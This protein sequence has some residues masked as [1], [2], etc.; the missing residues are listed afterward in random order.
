MWT[1]VAALFFL[2]AADHIAEGSKALDDGK[3]E[4]AAQS[5]SKAIAADPKDVAAHFHLA[6]A[7]S[8]LNRDAEGIAEYRKALQLE[9]GLFEAELN[10]GILYL[11]QKDPAEA[12]PLLEHAA[13][14]KPREFRPR[15]YAAEAQLQSG[16]L[17]K[18]EESFRTALEL[19]PKSA[20]AELGLALWRG[21]PSWMPR[22][23][24]TGR[25]R[26][27]NPSIG[28]RCWNW[29]VFMKRAGSPARRRGSIESFRITRP[30]SSAL[31][32]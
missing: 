22:P 21:N 24:T 28:S 30:R 26:R 17:E 5:F 31:A 10:L 15:Y 3:Y 25:P 27:S 13:E 7:Y 8:L 32:R 6:L 16:A 20:D 2:Q 29:R 14:Q 12:L 11:R 18:A 4:A 23:R 9:P 1:V 19:D